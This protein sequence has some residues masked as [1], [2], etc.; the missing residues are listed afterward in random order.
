MLTDFGLLKCEALLS[1]V[2]VAPLH[3]GCAQVLVSLAAP[4]QASQ[5]DAI[6]EPDALLFPVRKCSFFPSRKFLHSGFSSGLA[7]SVPA[8]LQRA[9]IEARFRFVTPTNIRLLRQAQSSSLPRGTR[10]VVPL[11]SRASDARPQR[12]DR[13]CSG[14]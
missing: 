12:R 6:E 5:L 3:V 7:S 1:P 8:S 2:Q 10:V 4:G 13:I 9:G 11:V 14:P